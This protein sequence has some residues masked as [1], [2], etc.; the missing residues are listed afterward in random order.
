M[1]VNLDFIRE[2]EVLLHQFEVRKDIKHLKKLLHPELIEIGYSGKTHSFNSTIAE[3]PN[4]E[5]PD[6]SVWSQDFEYIELAPDLIQIIYKEARVDKNG[7]MSRFA[8]RTSI[9]VKNNDQWQMRYHQGTPTD[10]FEKLK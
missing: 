3:V 4:E 2:K 10:P 7:A 6:Y 1:E 8:K 9:W 5:K